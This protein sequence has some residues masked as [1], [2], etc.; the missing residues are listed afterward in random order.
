[1]QK[2]NNKL[3]LLQNLLAK[4]KSTIKKVVDCIPSDMVC[5]DFSVAN[6]ALMDIDLKNTAAFSNFVNDQIH[7]KSGK[8]GIGGY[9]EERII[10]ARSG[11]FEGEE[12]RSVH[13]G[14]DIWSAAYTPVYAP[15]DAIVHSF[16]NNEGFGNYGNTLILEHH[17]EDLAFYTLYG[18]LSAASI[19]ALSKGQEM[20][21]GNK[22]AE[23]GDFSD[24]GDWPP[25]LHFQVMLDMEGHEG[26]YPGVA[27]PSER[28]S[29]LANCPDPGLIL[30]I[31]P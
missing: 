1:M 15:L 23:I 29:Y 10:Y 5:L 31:L 24:N 28:E 12:P 25:H 22:I 30:Q 3:T 13:L 26:D 18:H 7:K 6:H 27:A 19:A 20:M 11:H 2:T 9:N 8:I 21:G 17:L 14:I 4:H 16:K